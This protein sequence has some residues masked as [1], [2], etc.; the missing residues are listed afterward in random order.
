MLLAVGPGVLG[1]EGVEPHHMC[2]WN[3]E[4]SLFAQPPIHGALSNGLSV[5]PLYNTVPDD[6]G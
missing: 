6:S 4:R 5:D 3:L 1:V 2:S